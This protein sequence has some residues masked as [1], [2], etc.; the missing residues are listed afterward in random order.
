MA[1]LT[2]SEVKE[3]LKVTGTEQDTFIQS[4]IDAAEAWLNSYTGRLFAPVTATRTYGP[5]AVD[6]ATLFLDEDL[7]SLTSITNGN[8][9][10][11][12]VN[13]DIVLLPRNATPKFAIRLKP[14]SSKSW[15]FGTT[16]DSP[17]QVNGTWGFATSA[18]EDVK[19]ALKRFIHWAYHTRDTSVFETSGFAEIGKIEA[20]PGF[21]IPV[22]RMLD[23]YRKVTLR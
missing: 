18:P 16:G 7:L 11:I 19:L 22:L 17:I 20:P 8:G 3:Y 5:E 12:D 2:L 9:S 10:T 21:P 6:G 1:I 15:D 13:N 23:R 4:L 14:S